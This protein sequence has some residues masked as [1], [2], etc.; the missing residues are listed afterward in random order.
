MTVQSRRDAALQALWAAE[1][2]PKRS[3][4]RLVYV[5]RARVALQLAERALAKSREVAR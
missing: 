4:W 1:A 2:R 3:P 5:T